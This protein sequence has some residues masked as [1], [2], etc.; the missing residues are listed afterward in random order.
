MSC[1][2]VE[3]GRGTPSL[4]KPR[5]TAPSISPAAPVAVISCDVCH[6]PGGI[7]SEIKY[8]VRPE[9][10]APA[11]GRFS[12]STVCG[13]VAAVRIDSFGWSDG[14]KEYSTLNAALWAGR[15]LSE[16]PIL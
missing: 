2:A 11:T 9:G 12:G 7:R 14:I 10:T 13:S 6:V 16:Y 8:A 1:R 5:P 15:T 3:R 4:V